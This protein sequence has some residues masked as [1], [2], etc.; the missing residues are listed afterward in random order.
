MQCGWKAFTGALLVLLSM[1]IIARG[2]DVGY[3]IESIAG[4]DDVGDGGSALEAQIAAAEGIALDNAGNLYLADNVNH[5]VRKVHL[6]TGVITTVAGNG[7][8]GFSGD[9]GPAAEAQ[10]DRPY[11]LAWKGGNLYIAD[12]GNGRVRVITPDG[13]IRENF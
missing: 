13:K 3:T 7:H 4:T 1:G 12:Y 10:L 2:A 8:A 9:G 5:R 6:A 11:G